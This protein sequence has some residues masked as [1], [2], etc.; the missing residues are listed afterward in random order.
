MAYHLQLCSPL[1]PPSLVL[2]LPCSGT[3]LVTACTEGHEFHVFSI[4]PHPWFSSES[5]VHHLYTLHRGTTSGVVR[6]CTH[7][8]TY[9]V[10]SY[11]HHPIFCMCRKHLCT[12][13]EDPPHPIHPP[14]PPIQL[15]NFVPVGPTQSCP[16]FLLGLHRV[17][18]I[19][20]SPHVNRCRTSASA[21]TADG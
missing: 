2:L 10:L 11:V 17:C 19:Y 20:S 6:K 18:S 12:L 21:V 8:H 15:S 4:L 16:L 13:H 1:L 3:M 9:L 5:A 14:P 7:T